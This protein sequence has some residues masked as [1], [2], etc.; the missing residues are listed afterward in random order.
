MSC[1]VY[2][3]YQLVY[4]Q[5]RNADQYGR[6]A[7]KCTGQSEVSDVISACLTSANYLVEGEPELHR[8]G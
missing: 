1:V 2:P 5:Q 7:V 6:R 4:L 8:L 3:D